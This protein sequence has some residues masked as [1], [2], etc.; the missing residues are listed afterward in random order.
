MTGMQWQSFMDT[1]NCAGKVAKN[2][3]T[4]ALLRMLLHTL[5]SE[6][7]PLLKRIVEWDESV[8]PQMASR[9]RFSETRQTFRGLVVSRAATNGCSC[10]GYGCLGR[11]SEVIPQLSIWEKGAEPECHFLR[12]M[13]WMIPL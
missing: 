6:I 7:G 10:G 11:V 9:I 4:R 13:S 8:L 3:E 1:I 5:P 2:T 12:E